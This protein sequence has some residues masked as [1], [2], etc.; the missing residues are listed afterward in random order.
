MKSAV[1][2]TESQELLGGAQRKC[3][4]VA[5]AAAAGAGT[6]RSGGGGTTDRGFLVRGTPH[7]RVL[8]TP[9]DSPRWQLTHRSYCTNTNEEQDFLTATTAEAAGA[10]CFGGEQPKP[11]QFVR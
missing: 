5:A 10:W 8:Q 9:V 7:D 6:E 2:A 11:L 4:D 1:S 3:R